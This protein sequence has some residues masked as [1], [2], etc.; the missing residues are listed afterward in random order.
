M[1]EPRK[2]IEDSLKANGIPLSLS[3][4]SVRIEC[5]RG[6]VCRG[7]KPGCKNPPGEIDRQDYVTSIQNF[8][9]EFNLK[10]YKNLSILYSLKI[11]GLSSRMHWS[12]F[13]RPGDRLSE[14]KK[15]GLKRMKWLRK[16]F[17]EVPIK[18]SACARRI[19]AINLSRQQ[20]KVLLP[21]LQDHFPLLPFKFYWL[22]IKLSLGLGFLTKRLSGDYT[23]LC[24]LI[25]RRVFTPLLVRS[26]YAPA[27]NLKYWENPLDQRDLLDNF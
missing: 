15:L 11:C 7:T 12:V 6:C 22:L 16:S 8:R 4:N 18:L 19:D 10:K 3:P 2:V 13:L 23:C 24:P 25:F 21:T 26:K 14:M 27:L 20:W 9:L 17:T 1:S 5:N